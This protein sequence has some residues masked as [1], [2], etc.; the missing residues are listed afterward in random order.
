MARYE[1]D[2]TV[3]GAGTAGLVT[4]AGAAGLGAKVALVEKDQLG[5][6]C[7]YTGCVPSKALIESA[8]LLARMRR[9]Q[10]FGLHPAEPSFD[11]P[12]VM[13]R[14]RRVIAEVGKHDRPERFQHLGVSISHGE[15]RFLSPHEV[16][17]DS[18]TLTTRKAVIATG[19]RTAIPP[20]EG[21]E[22]TG[23]I[24][25]VTAFQLTRLPQS[26]VILGGGPIGLEFAQMFARF[27]VRV[28]V[29]EVVGQLLPREDPEIGQLLEECLVAEGIEVRNCTKAFRVEK[30]PTGKRIHGACV[31]SAHDH[32]KQPAHFDVEEIF[33]A[34]GRRPNVE[35]LDL[36][37][38]GVEICRQ[39]VAINAGLRTTA[40]NIWAAGDITGKYLF[41]H[42]AEYQGRLVVGNALF[43][44]RRKANYRVVPWTTFTDPEV[45]RVGLT[46]TEARER[47]GE[48]RVYR[49]AFG[50]LDR[51]IIDGEGKGFAKVVCT[52]KGKI[53]GA[54]LI[55][56]H[57]GEV[58]QELVLAM[59]AGIKIQAL[60]QTI[61]AY[62]TLTEVVRRTA[63]AYYR[64]KLFSGR[65]PR[66]FK[67]VF[68][69]LR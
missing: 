23:F 4:A 14:M 44:L 21:L 56:P 67:R 3:I 32:F 39:G 65:L 36:E 29:L 43:P 11:F 26:V 53:L 28:V 31:I 18:R 8:K 54:H 62:P 57:A 42:V 25:H 34:T 68:D 10:E 24:D 40:T 35:G 63:D 1:Y 66:I 7:L 51:A 48:I 41:T 20:I 47:H 2:L 19:S 46:E 37:K 15:A 22:E 9:A 27:G 5:G 49:Y 58:I 61:H 30:M 60:S 13:D 33:I 17:V 12:E 38:A 45:A 59:K 6:E 50:D 69:F 52:P 16:R 55:G 64:E